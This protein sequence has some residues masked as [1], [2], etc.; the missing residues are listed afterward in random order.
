LNSGNSET[1]KKKE[2]RSLGF[3]KERNKKEKN[4]NK[5]KKRQ[6]PWP[7]LFGGCPH[8]FE[9]SQQLVVVVFA[10]KEGLSCD[11]FCKNTPC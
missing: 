5:N 8:D 7:V 4:K 9:D 10:R 11:H 3:N 1:L 2:K 6:S